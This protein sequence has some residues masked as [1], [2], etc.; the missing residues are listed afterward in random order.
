MSIADEIT[1][2]NNAKN[3]L[4]TKLNAKNDQ[5]H[6]ITNETIDDYG[7]F[8]DSIVELNGET[9]TVTPTTS[10][11]IITPTGTG[12]NALTSVTVNAVTSAIDNNIQA[13]NIKKDVSILGVTGT[14]EG[15]SLPYIRLDYIESTGTQYIDTGVLPYKT[16]T[17]FK[18]QM[19]SQQADG[20]YLCGCWNAD[21]NRYYPVTYGSGSFYTYNRSNSGTLLSAYNNAEHT[22][23]YNDEN[24]KVYFDGVE[25]ATISD[26]TTQAT[27]SIYLFALHG[28]AG[29]TGAYIGRIMYIK[30]WDKNTNT[31]I[32]DIIPVKRKS[33]NVIGM[34]DRVTETFYTN[35][36]TGNFIAGGVYQGTDTSDA[37]A[38]ADDILSGKTAYA[39]GQKITGIL[40]LP[41]TKLNYIESSG[42]QYIRTDYVPKQNTGYEITYMCGT[43]NTYEG[44]FGY[45]NYGVTPDLRY[46][47]LNDY[48]YPNNLR[49][50]IKSSNDDNSYVMT[51]TYN[52]VHTLTVDKNGNY[53]MDGTTTGQ[54]E[55]FEASN[56]SPIYIFGIR[57]ANGGVGNLGKFKLYKFKIF[58]NDT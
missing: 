36:G 17:E 26:L 48:N 41:F 42:T 9:A 37:T 51:A 31:L 49:I 19:A 56:T 11:Q 30:M 2:I 4:K 24:N 39:N 58:E 6:Q 13:E 1:R 21:N 44:L 52:E 15:S 3:T 40:S 50:R 16:K 53:N 35:Q 5:E 34:Y 23:L 57:Q 20:C 8:V 14:Y 25:K 22:V 33:D 32:R 55:G 10:Q 38:I 12:K 29:V 45:S 7:D 43:T 47:V 46:T 28:S 27:N 18:F 54:M